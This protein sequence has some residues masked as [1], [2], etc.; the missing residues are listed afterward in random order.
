MFKSLLK[1]VLA[2]IAVKLLANYQRLSIQLLKIEAAK[3]Y[4]H[5]VR[6][7]RES[8]LGLMRRGLEIVLIGVGLLLVHAGLFILIPWTV[9]VKALL[10]I[11]LG[12]GYVAIGCI[13]LH[14]A[15]D[16]KTWMEKSGVKE[17]LDEATSQSK[18]D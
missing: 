6:M 8:A 16:E 5:G 17:M 13:A 2:G 10:G 1:G 9:K 14:A 7:A 12:F 15:M 18:K 11:L 3:A 4:L